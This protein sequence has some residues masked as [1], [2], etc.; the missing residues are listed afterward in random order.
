MSAW[1][2]HE[3]HIPPG[4]GIYYASSLY[5]VVETWDTLTIH[6]VSTQTLLFNRETSMM[7]LQEALSS[8]PSV[9]VEVRHPFTLLL[10]Y[11]RGEGVSE[12]KD[13]VLKTLGVN[14]DVTHDHDQHMR[15]VMRRRATRAQDLILLRSLV[16]HSPT[17]PVVTP[18]SIGYGLT[19]GHLYLSSEYSLGRATIAKTIHKAAPDGV[20]WDVVDHVVDTCTSRPHVVDLLTSTVSS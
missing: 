20:C 8:I 14:L 1:H 18:S 15:Y 13:V 16:P 17:R 7:R 6:P 12:V 9:I 19:I 11:A 4:L 3:H 10:S 2:R 5:E